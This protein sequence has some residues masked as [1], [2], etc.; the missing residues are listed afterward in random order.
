MNKVKAVEEFEVSTMDPA[1]VGH[2]G[3]KIVGIVLP[4]SVLVSFLRFKCED[5]GC[6]LEM[7]GE[8]ARE[9]H[10]KLGEKI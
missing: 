6:T 4:S 8:Q 7:T 9:L 1:L 10:K 5:I 2:E 3:R